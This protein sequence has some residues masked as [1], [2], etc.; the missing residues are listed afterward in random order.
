MSCLQQLDARS[1]EVDKQC[2]AALKSSSDDTQL[3]EQYHVTV[4][5]AQLSERAVLA[6]SVC[7]K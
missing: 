6:I 2:I 5:M 7:A 1:K 3:S 4:S